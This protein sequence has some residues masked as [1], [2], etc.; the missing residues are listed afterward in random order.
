[1]FGKNYI[2]P[3]EARSLLFSSFSK[4]ELAFHKL[5]I[6]ECYNRVLAEN[7]IASEDL[8]G[9]SRSTV[10]G[11]AVRSADTFGAKDTMPAY[12]SIKNEV[13]MGEPASFEIS[14]GEA[15]KIPTGGMLPKGADAVLMLENAQ[16]VS[17]DM[18]EAMKSVA[19]NENVILAGEDIQKGTQVLS[20]GRRL[21]AQ[22]IGALAGLGITQV[23]VYRKPVVAIISTGDEIL[24]AS[25]VLQPGQVRDINS[26]TLT[27]LINDNGGIPVKKG[28]IKDE[29][30]LIKKTLSDALE[31]SDIVIVS[32][33][34]SA[35][36]KDM[37]AA[38]INE[39]GNPGVLF[40]GV[41]VKPGKPVIGAFIGNK[42]VIGLPGHPAATA[43]SFDMFVRPLLE[44]LCG[45]HKN[46][47]SKNFAYA[48]IKK[49][50]ASVAGREDHVR[51]ALELEGDELYAVP[52]LGKSG[53]I[54]TL[55]KAD[56]VV[57]I[58]EG[59]LGIDAG[60]DVK[61]KLF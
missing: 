47:I 42:P 55:V 25:S 45:L 4:P 30:D 28:I 31:S 18:I 33:G 43:V 10:D 29:Y 32:G 40:H 35:G 11:Y 21:R 56:G 19:P 49:S 59:K 20:K 53:L 48:K 13:F 3:Q 58:P 52:V 16:A 60:E 5:P 37:T 22:D 14:K 1:M 51:V 61:V 39:L 17:V 36:V 8:P 54:T 50:I 7:I 41:A 23:N 12:L 34:T 26:F 6:E 24:P 46:K 9:F 27:G 2:L 38:I 57:V 44:V 15:A